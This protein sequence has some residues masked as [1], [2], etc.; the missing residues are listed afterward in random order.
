MNT[1]PHCQPLDATTALQENTENIKEMGK[2]VNQ[3][4]PLSTACKWQGF[5][6]GMG[7]VHTPSQ[8]V[9][10][11]STPG[12]NPPA[13]SSY[14]CLTRWRQKKTAKLLKSFKI[15]VTTEKS[16]LENY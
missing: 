15:S 16:L 6:L 5:T 11:L 10:V 13:A 8:H 3:S 14:V 1:S 4:P 7:R 2:K 12:Q 9:L